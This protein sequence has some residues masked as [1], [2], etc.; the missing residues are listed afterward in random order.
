MTL[1][2]HS[3]PKRSVLKRNTNSVK[4]EF[5]NETQNANTNQVFQN[6]ASFK[7][8]NAWNSSPETQN[9]QRN[10]N[11]TQSEQNTS[12]T[13]PVKLKRMK[14][15]DYDC[16][17]KNLAQHFAAPATP[18]ILLHLVAYRGVKRIKPKCNQN[19]TQSERN[20]IKTG[21]HTTKTQSERDANKTETKKRETET[22]KT[23]VSKHARL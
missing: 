8:Q 12:E 6:A 13:K 22:I 1:H 19:E 5:R 9:S 21:T 23:T 2:V 7:T 11:E 14:R 3:K 4:S 10:Q 16:D 15:N 17:A 18:G 20:A